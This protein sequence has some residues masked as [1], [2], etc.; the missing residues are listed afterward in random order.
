M[1]ARFFNAKPLKTQQKYLDEH[2]RE[3]DAFTSKFNRTSNTTS[4]RVQTLSS[5]Y[6]DGGDDNE[7]EVNLTT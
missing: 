5:S 3:L 2:A 1:G 7:H 6:E 4:A